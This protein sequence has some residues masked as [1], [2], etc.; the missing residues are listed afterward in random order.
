MFQSSFLWLLRRVVALTK[1]FNSLAVSLEHQ[2]HISCLNSAIV[3]FIPF[4]ELFTSPCR[5]SSPN[6]ARGRSCTTDAGVTPV[7]GWSWACSWR[8][9]T[10]ILQPGVLLELVGRAQA[11]RHSRRLVRGLLLLCTTQLCLGSFLILLGQSLWWLSRCN[12]GS[13]NTTWC[14]STTSSAYVSRLPRT[15]FG[16]L[17]KPSLLRS[18]I[19]IRNFLKDRDNLVGGARRLFFIHLREGSLN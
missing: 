13:L 19:R 17:S 12:D 8:C 7:L 10:T 1:S 2:Q 15:T 9:C 18:T 4:T 3:V 16:T 5:R 6:T 11:H 14:G